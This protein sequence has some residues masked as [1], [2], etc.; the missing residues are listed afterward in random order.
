MSSECEAFRNRF[1]LRETNPGLAAMCSRVVTAADERFARTLWQYLR[2]V[3]RSRLQTQHTWVVYDLG[4]AVQTRAQLEERYSWCL[5]KRFEFDKWPH[6]LRLECQNYAWKPAL[7]ATEVLNGEGIVLWFD[8]A[9]LFKGAIDAA[10]EIARQ[11]GIWYLRGQ[12]PL[13]LHAD[14]RALDLM[15]VPLEVRHLSE[16]VTGALAFSAADP[17]ARRIATEWRD[18]ALQPDIIAPDGATVASHKYDQALL[19]GVI[20]KAVA[21]GELSL[22]TD[23]IDISSSHPV[24]WMTSRNKV[25]RSVPVWADSGVRGYYAA[26]KFFDVGWLRFKRRAD[27]TLGGL[28]RHMVE[29][30]AVSVTDHDS[31]STRLLPSPRYGYLADPF[32][33]A[34][35]D[36][37]WVFAEQFCCAEDRGKLVVLELNRD[38]SVKRK[39]DIT[40]VPPYAAL[41]CH[42]SFPFLF[43]SGGRSFLIPETSRRRTL[44]L[45]EC[46]AWPVRWRLVRR[47][48]FDI[49]AADTA[50]I[51]HDGRWWFLTSVRRGGGSRHLEIYSCE[52]LLSGQ[53]HA[54]PVNEERLDANSPHGTGRNAGMIRRAGV[55]GL[56]RFVQKSEHYYGQGGEFRK[57]SVLT[58]EA[59]AE[60]PA[61][62]A[63]EPLLTGG[64]D[65]CHHYTIAKGYT[66][67]DRR[68]RT[69]P[70]DFVR[71]LWRS[72]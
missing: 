42:A 10:I 20:F 56:L 3:E 49:D 22:T 31:G 66:A 4:L 23:E 21:A 46:E 45:Y 69:R 72:L 36:G 57:I 14:Q 67:S 13:Y 58:K 25:G 24:R 52:D 29:H 61:P 62:A 1:T 48:L 55:G 40:C 54:H 8:C 68:T 19:S 16:C 59:F 11:N 12:T 7:L 41:D 26:Y 15:A 28:R 44:D 71:S 53:L 38:L 60:E 43:E 35:T 63:D 65:G 27:K 32:V 37:T 30:F 50:A 34:S 5:F 18:Y 2:S 6:H 33:W 70:W 17:N 47:L 39:A 51:W 9:T 64:L